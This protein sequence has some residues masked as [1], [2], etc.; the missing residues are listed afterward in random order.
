MINWV[1]NLISN[2]FIS[3]DPFVTY[4][5]AEERFLSSATDVYDL[6]IKQR[7]WDR[8]TTQERSRYM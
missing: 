7:R 2:F 5:K 4:Q 1:K 8:M 6:E 3:V